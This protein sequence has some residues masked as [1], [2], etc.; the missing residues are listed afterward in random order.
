[1]CKPAE[2]YHFRI[3]EST[4]MALTKLSFSV[5]SGT[6]GA[7]SDVRKLS[8]GQ[9]LVERSR[10]VHTDN[11][12]HAGT[13]AGFPMKAN[14]QPYLNNSKGIIRTRK[15]QDTDEAEIAS[16]ISLQGVISVNRILFRDLLN[17]NIQGGIT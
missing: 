6:A 10:K 7:V 8:S 5:I 4:V 14:F 2:I 16:E 17:G 11:L 3:S 1:M 12:M 13:L 9:G 15:L